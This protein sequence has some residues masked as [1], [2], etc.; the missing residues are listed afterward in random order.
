MPNHNYNRSAQ[1]GAVRRGGSSGHSNPGANAAHG[2][3]R[4]SDNNQRG[5]NEVIRDEAQRQEM[6]AETVEEISGWANLGAL[7]SAPLAATTA[8]ME[9]ALPSEYIEHVKHRY[10]KEYS[11]VSEARFELRMF[12][13]KRYFI[14]CSV[15]KS[16]PMFSDAVDGV[17]HEMIMYTRDYERFGRDFL[18]ETLH[19]APARDSIPDPDGR[20]W[21]DLIYSLLFR[22]HKGTQ[23]EW[24]RFFRHPLSRN[25]IKELL[26][27]SDEELR[28]KYFRKEADEQL[29]NWLLESLK[30]QFREASSLKERASRRKGGDRHAA[31]AQELEMENWE[32]NHYSYENPNYGAMLA[33]F[34]IMHS[35]Y[36]QDTYLQEMVNE[37]P[38]EEREDSSR[39]SCIASGCSGGT[40][41]SGGGQNVDGGSGSCSGSSCSGESCSGSSCSSSSCSS[42]DSSSSSNDSGGSS[43]SSGGSS[44]S[45]SSCGGGGGD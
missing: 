14:L 28:R 17:W 42:G 26:S 4:I 15:F 12:E 10:L 24:G 1:Q 20:A 41:C 19:H 30:K 6:I 22:I 37:L 3:R 44:C 23:S 11:N 25:R 7:P 38:P 36:N 43:D 40:E 33:G 21:F 29:V 34:M 31:D 18:G 13:L 35:V 45:S 39:S 9:R 8:A 2:I 32:S 27:I 5:R 16:V